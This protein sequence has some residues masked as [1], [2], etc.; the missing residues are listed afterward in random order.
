VSKLANVY[1]IDLSKVA[2]LGDPRKTYN[3]TL[4]EPEINAIH[5]AFG[6]MQSASAYAGFSKFCNHYGPTM[7]ALSKRLIVFDDGN[8]PREVK[9]D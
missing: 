1:D 2:P 6:F 5:A 9:N 8:A 4:T 7:E 3:V